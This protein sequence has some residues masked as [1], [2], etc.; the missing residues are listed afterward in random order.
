[1]TEVKKVNLHA[2]IIFVNLME[3]SSTLENF[4]LPALGGRTLILV[5]IE[6]G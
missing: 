4:V 3:I 1:M 5:L 6:F 2:G